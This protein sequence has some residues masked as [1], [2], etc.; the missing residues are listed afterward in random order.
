MPIVNPAE[1]ETLIATWR[2]HGDTVALASGSFDVLHVG[3]VRYLQG[4]KRRADRLVVAVSDDA[5]V[6]ALEGAGRPILSA[7]DRAELVAALD[8]VDTVIIC[9][10]TAVTDLLESVRPDVHCE[11]TQPTEQSTRELIARIANQP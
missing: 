1:L 9:S 2:D 4:A 11:D 3:H 5:S 8:A 6:Q 10:E 7:A